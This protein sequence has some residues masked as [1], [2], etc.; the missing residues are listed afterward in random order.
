[1]ESYVG[2]GL[3]VGLGTA[4]VMVA[5]WLVLK[6]LKLTGTL[7]TFLLVVGGVFGASVTAGLLLNWPAE[8]TL[9]TFLV[10]SFL[11]LAATWLSVG[12]HRHH[13]PSEASNR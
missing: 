4:S 13:T 12:A 8:R 2:I 5:G 9:M 7:A 10:M 6:S 3:V 1:M 11:P